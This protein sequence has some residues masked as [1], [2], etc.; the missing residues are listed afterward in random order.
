MKI[1]VSSESTIDLSKEELN[2]Y[3][4]KIV[5]FTIIL[6]ERSDFDGVI[7]TQ[8]LFDYYDQTGETPKTSAI[9]ETQY[10]EHFSNLFL[11]YDEIIHIAFS[12][13]LSSAYANLEKVAKKNKHIHV[14]D[15][16]SL[17]SGIGLLA[18]YASKLVKEGLEVDEIVTK[19]NKRVPYVQVSSVISTLDYLYKGGRCNALVKKTADLLRIRPQIVSKN[20]ELIIGKKYIGKQLDCIKKYC[21]DTLKEFNNPDLSIGI[22][23]YT[24]ATSEMIEAAKE[25]LVNRGFKEILICQAGCTVTT[26]CGPRVVGIYYINDGDVNN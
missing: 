15:S 9:N 14:I 4:I 17:S 20:G 10:E 18:I 5:P 12:S 16:L 21:D 6:G 23:A 7:T 8:D 11:E 2:K 3:N 22:V 24:S 26:H 13:K 1:C 19:V 25:K